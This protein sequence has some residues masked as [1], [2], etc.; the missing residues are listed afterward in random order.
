MRG[1]VFV[2]LVLNWM[3]ISGRKEKEKKV[4]EKKPNLPESVQSAIE[5]MHASVKQRVYKT[6]DGSRCQQERVES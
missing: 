2:A 3:F 4:P 6:L 1:D 5:L